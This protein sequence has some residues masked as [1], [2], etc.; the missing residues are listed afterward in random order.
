VSAQTPTP[1]A[2]VLPFRRPAVTPR[3]RRRSVWARLGRPFAQAFAMVA[4]PTAVAAWLFSSPTF[5]LARIEVTGNRHVEPAWV[6]KTLAPLVGENLLRLP[7][8][9]VEARLRL[10]PWV[11]QVTIDKRLPR[12]LAVELAERE[13]KALLRAGSELFYLDGA[14][15][16][17][18]PFD[19]LRG[20]GDLLLV[21]LATLP[22]EDLAGAFAIADELARVRPDWARSLS[23]VEV[24]GEGDFRLFLGALPFPL[25][26]RSGTLAERLP[27]VASLLPEIER[28]YA[29][30]D[31]L[32]LRF[33]RRIILQ[34]ERSE[35]WQKRKTTS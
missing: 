2:R 23:E 16:I 26:V 21:S 22:G 33:A 1:E 14:G 17:I 31:A 29:V 15:R 20:P 27:V 11:D 7:L 3:V 9:A 34:P 30:V 24:L 12:V 10:N 13:P 18:A 25:L 5:A 28:R 6:E 8:A 19:P 32:D 4:V 35:A